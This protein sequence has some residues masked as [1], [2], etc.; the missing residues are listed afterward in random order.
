MIH[1]KLGRPSAV[2]NFHRHPLRARFVCG[3]GNAQRIAAGLLHPHAKD[4]DRLP[5]AA[6]RKA[7]KQLYA[8][9]KVDFPKH[10]AVS[11]W[12][13]CAV[14]QHGAQ[15]GLPQTGWCGN[16]AHAVVLAPGVHCFQ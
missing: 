4:R 9:P 15:H 10:L 5:V 12:G 3:I 6:L 2:F 16:D 13:C 8:C 14:A 11:R 1:E 7:V